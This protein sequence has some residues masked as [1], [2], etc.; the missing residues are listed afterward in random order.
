MPTGA[1]IVWC[2]TRPS[3]RWAAED[4]QC[5]L[6]GLEQWVRVADI[7][8]LQAKFKARAEGKKEGEFAGELKIW[9]RMLHRLLDATEP[10]AA[11]QVL[12]HWAQTVPSA[13]PSDEMLDRLESAPAEWRSLLLGES[14]PDDAPC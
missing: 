3:L 10:G 5:W 13:W 1:W 12:Q 11:D 7:P 4:L 14:S 8:I 6:E 2:W 9:G